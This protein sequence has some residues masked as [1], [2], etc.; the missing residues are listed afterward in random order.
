MVDAGLE[1][2]VVLN[3]VSM[4]GYTASPTQEALQMFHYSHYRANLHTWLLGA[5]NVSMKPPLKSV[6]H[7]ILIVKEVLPT[8]TLGF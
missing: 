8:D 5:T 4:P 7:W 2:G 1:A 6:G 3:T